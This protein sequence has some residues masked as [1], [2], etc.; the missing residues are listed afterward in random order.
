MRLSSYDLECLENAKTF[1]DADM[2]RH[3]TIAE[4]AAHSGMNT[5]KLRAGFKQLYG[6][7][8][9]HYLKEQRL[10]KAKYLLETSDKS[11]K[12]I[13]HLLGYKHTCNF[14]TNYRKRFGKG[15]ASWRKNGALS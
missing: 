11:L 7:G 5:S 1:I 9:Y 2:N 6:Q 14:I 13:S 4:I 8:L 12:Q 3:H 15:P 10:E